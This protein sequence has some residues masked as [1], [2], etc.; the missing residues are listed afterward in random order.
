[1]H[2][3]VIDGTPYLPADAAPSIGIGVT[4]RNRPDALAT[5]LKHLRT[6]LPPAA[7]LVIVDDASDKPV[8]DAD[9]RF[10]ENVGIAVAKN[11]CLELLY[12]AGCEHIFLF[13]ND[14]YPIADEWW[15]PYVD[16]PEPHL[17]W[18]FDRPAKATKRQVE[19]LYLG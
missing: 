7:K 1:M 6:Y 13:D 16:S 14:T 18:I 5:T 10:S 19:V 8:D 2:Q 4:T 15:K 11:K 17:M 9:H 3:V 12:A